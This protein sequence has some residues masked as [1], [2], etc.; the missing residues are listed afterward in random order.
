MKLPCAHRAD[1]DV[2]KL[3]DYLLSLDHPVGRFKARVFARAGYRRT[4]A[5]VLQK[6]ILDLARHG[7]A[8]PQPLGTFGQK[9]IVRGIL[10][11]PNGRSLAVATIWI[12]RAGEQVPRFVTA[13]PGAAI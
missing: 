13:Y 6:D 5:A 12:V 1:I 8:E 3:T 10:Q 2:A 9:F 7:D 11:G 4:E